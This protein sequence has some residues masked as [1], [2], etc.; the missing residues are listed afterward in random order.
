MREIIRDGYHFN[1]V[2]ATYNGWDFWG[3]FA[4]GTWEASLL[5]EIAAMTPGSLLFDVGA[6]V[7]PI[8]MWAA[9]HGV[10]VIAIEP[11]PAAIPVLE[12]NIQSSDLSSLIT[13][14]P[15]AIMP[16]SGMVTM[17]VQNGGGDSQSSIARTNMPESIQ[18]EAVTLQELINHYGRPDLVKIDVEGIEGLIVPAF[19]PTLRSMGSAM[20]LATHWH[21]IP[22]EHKGP[23]E[24]EL[25]QWPSSR[26]V[27][28]DANL[29]MPL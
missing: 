22:E 29:Y 19:G 3:S 16:E 11:D 5:G 15:Y 27:E 13:I 4:N 24:Y 23:L 20:L 9:A 17:N 1:I 25:S 7:G 12:Q 18:V 28:S 6:W 10:R 8:S 26:R 14:V 21:W 2:D